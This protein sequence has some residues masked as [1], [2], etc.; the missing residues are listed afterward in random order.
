MPGLLTN[1]PPLEVVEKRFWAKVKK[2]ETCW[3]WTGA[4]IRGYGAFGWWKP[5][6]KTVYAH[7]LAYELLRGTLTDGLVLDHL[8]MTPLCVNPDHLE[9]VTATENHR[10]WAASVKVCPRGHD[11]TEENTYRN[12]KTGHRSCIKCRNIV[13]AQRYK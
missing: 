7:R 5:Q 1:S 9:E 13:N 12:S 3:L 11:Y 8:C 4:T 2:T 6:K 10:R